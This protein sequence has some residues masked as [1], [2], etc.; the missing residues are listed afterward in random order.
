M[1]NGGMRFV[2]VEF[3]VKVKHWVEKHPD[4]STP[5]VDGHLTHLVPAPNR[6]GLEAFYELHVWAWENNNPTGNFADWNMKVA[7]DKQPGD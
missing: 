3:I 5:D 7:C 4:G 1:A 6:Y 2:G